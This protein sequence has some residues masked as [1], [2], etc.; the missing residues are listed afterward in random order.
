[1]DNEGLIAAVQLSDRD[2]V[3]QPEPLYISKNDMKGLTWRH[4]AILLKSLYTQPPEAVRVKYMDDEGDW[5]E[6]GSDAELQEALKFTSRSGEILQLQVR[7]VDSGRLIDL[8]DECI[9]AGPMSDRSSQNS[10]VEHRPGGDL[11]INLQSE[12][13]FVTYV[14]TTD[15]GGDVA[16]MLRYPYPAEQAPLVYPTHSS[17]NCLPATPLLPAAPLVPVSATIPAYRITPAMPMVEALV[18]TEVPSE[19]LTEASVPSTPEETLTCRGQ[20]PSAPPPPQQSSLN[21]W[22]QAANLSPEEKIRFL[23]RIAEAHHQSQRDGSTAALPDV[24]PLCSDPSPHKP[25]LGQNNIPNQDPF[26]VEGASPIPTSAQA[27]MNF[28]RGQSVE[29]LTPTP[30]D[31]PRGSP[32]SNGKFPRSSSVDPSSSSP[33]SNPSFTQAP[34]TMSSF[35]Q[36]RR[37]ASADKSAVTKVAATKALY[38]SAVVPK[39]KLPKKVEN[40]APVPMPRNLPLME[41]AQSGANAVAIE[42]PSESESYH[43]AA[44]NKEEEIAASGGASSTSAS[45]ET[46]EILARG[47]SVAASMD[48]EIKANTQADSCAVAPVAG[49]TR[50]SKEGAVTLKELA[51]RASKPKQLPAKK[52][53]VLQKRPLA[54][55]KKEES[56]E[57]QRA[58]SFGVGARPKVV[59]KKSKK[60]AEESLTKRKVP[61]KQEKKWKDGEKEPLKDE[62]SG[63]TAVMLDCSK[64]ETMAL[65]YEDFLKH[66]KKVKKDL[67][68]SIVKDVTK[69]TDKLLKKSFSRS[70]SE[71]HDIEFRFC[72][73]KGE[74]GSILHKGITCDHCDLEIVGVRYKCGN[75]ADFD[76]CEKCENSEFVHDPTHVFLK[77]RK[78]ARKAGCVGKE[79]LPLLRENI[80]EAERDWEEKRKEKEEKMKAKDERKKEKE[81]RKREKKERK[82]LAAEEK[83]NSIA[84]KNLDDVVKALETLSPDL[85][86]KQRERPAQWATPYESFPLNISSPADGQEVFD[87][88]QEREKTGMIE[89]VEGMINDCTRRRTLSTEAVDGDDPDFCPIQRKRLASDSSGSSIVRL[90]PPLPV[91][92][93]ET[94][95]RSELVVNVVSLPSEG[96]GQEETESEEVEQKLPLLPNLTDEPK[97]D[98]DVDSM[99]G[100]VASSAGHWDDDDDDA[101]SFVSGSSYEYFHSDDSEEFCILTPPAHEDYEEIVKDEA[102]ELMMAAEKEAG[103]SVPSV[104]EEKE[105]VCEDSAE[106]VDT[107]DE[108]KTPGNAEEQQQ[109]G[110]GEELVEVVSR[111][112]DE[113]NNEEQNNNEEVEDI[114]EEEDTDEENDEIRMKLIQEAFESP[115]YSSDMRF[116]ELVHSLTEEEKK[117]YQQML[118]TELDKEKQ[119]EEEKQMGQEKREVIEERLEE[120]R[121]KKLKTR[122]R[123]RLRERKLLQR[124][125]MQMLR[126]EDYKEI[127]EVKAMQASLV[128]KQLEE[129]GV[130][131][132]AGAEQVKA[133]SEKAQVQ[134]QEEKEP[135]A[136]NA[137]RALGPEEQKSYV[138][139]RV[140]GNPA[141]CRNHHLNQMLEL[142]VQKFAALDAGDHEAVADIER[143]LRELDRQKYIDT[144]RMLEERIRQ[145]IA[146]SSLSDDAELEEQN[147][148]AVSGS[149]SRQTSVASS[150][151]QSE[152]TDSSS[153]TSVTTVR[154]VDCQTAPEPA[155]PASVIIQNVASG[156]SKAASTAFSTAKDVFYS[157]QAKQNERKMQGQSEKKDAALDPKRP[158]IVKVRGDSEAYKALTNAGA[159]PHAVPPG[160]WVPKESIWTP[161]EDWMPPTE[162]TWKPPAST[163]K[164]PPSTWRPPQSSWKPPQSAWKPQKSSWKPPQVDWAP[165]QYEWFSVGSDCDPAELCGATSP[166]A[167]PSVVDGS[168]RQ[169]SAVANGGSTE[170]EARSSVDEPTANNSDVADDAAVK[171]CGEEPAVKRNSA[172]SLTS[173][174]PPVSLQSSPI[175]SLTIADSALRREIQGMQRLIEMGFANREKNRQLLIKFDGDLECVVQSLLQEE[176]EDHWAFHRH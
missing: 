139:K 58:E 90:S 165:Q 55:V 169:E 102:E 155:G 52:V 95:A 156:V 49:E 94:P 43:G 105:K 13:Q 63:E 145:Q 167:I 126:E 91:I 73:V 67:H 87:V 120:D 8:Q 115:E 40:G 5:V 14:P 117:L 127:L 9:D 78:P 171:S 85:E 82:R 24:E 33:S 109:Q 17:Q 12:S 124:K 36:P 157:L 172:S 125:R 4:F 111:G 3:D 106:V 22:D 118:R 114:E 65:Q 135:M 18:P 20:V 103:T 128:N 83:G 130:V 100:Q 137:F 164:P 99:K 136:K 79:R 96:N 54:E 62:E 15:P 84:K 61:E 31:T 50:A 70:R 48:G 37:S 72:N 23:K 42:M 71:S 53:K 86:E 134:K 93:S 166:S 161:P 112:E 32:G 74:T 35:A 60:K 51:K 30:I 170:A 29:I 10:M 92:I 113:N 133:G 6:L 88:W 81:E 47:G 7:R 44:S 176:G 151:G 1:M 21:L 142:E 163:W 116:A 26:D 122:E 158:I 131:A 160:G 56:T 80:Y 97:V 77:L 25:C 129:N 68:S 146:G 38:C 138:L 132:G 28:K 144:T 108:A 141:V 41:G 76:L 152:K 34:P 98:N 119:T 123:E 153:V 121:S 27:S 39:A 110:V 19:P 16:P 66:M 149:V 104:E 45:E 140:K 57:V 148:A 69:H 46:G 175:A 150:S 11:G 173:S 75:C 64:K 107:T 89:A 174:S 143:R 159:V 59:E 162:S 168:E 147:P 101:H 2:E 154:D